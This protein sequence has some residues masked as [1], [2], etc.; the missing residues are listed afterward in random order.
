MTTVTGAPAKSP[1]T[2]SGWNRD[3]TDFLYGL[4]TARAGLLIVSVVLVLIPLGARS[5]ALGLVTVPLA[6]A[7]V[8]LALIWVSGRPANEW[9]GD[10][11]AFTRAKRRQET[12]FRGGAAG[13]RAT[14]DAPGTP[15]MDLPGSLSPIRFLRTETGTGAHMAVVHHPINLTYTAVCRVESRGLALADTGQQTSRVAAWGA[16]LSS[17]C[18]ENNVFVRVQVC[19]RAEPGDDTALRRWHTDHVVAGVPEIAIRNAEVALAESGRASAQHQAY[20]AFTMSAS[21][22]RGDIRV[23]GDGD[24]GAAAVLV[25]RVRAMEDVLRR[26]H[27]PVQEWLDVR[28]LSEVV[29]SGFDPAGGQALAHRRVSARSMVASGANTGL[30]PG[31]PPHLAGPVA[32]SVGWK[33]YRHDSGVSATFGVYEWPRHAVHSTVLIALLG[34]AGGYGARRSFSLHYEPLGPREA[35]RRLQAE[36]TKADAKRSMKAKSGTVIGAS[37]TAERTMIAKQDAET[38]AGHGLVR[39][40]GYVTVTVTD[41]TLLEQ[42]VADLQADASASKIELRRMYGSQDTAFFASTLPL[43]TGLP[44][45]RRG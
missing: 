28:D 8:A 31:V 17:L 18:S 27:L 41:E 19:L 2:Y 23:A 24:V 12:E 40:V 30:E 32:T 26:A 1:A 34:H 15:A 35:S 6:L 38:A 9:I 44:L 13:G 5:L 37:E 4:S 33:Q 7:L 20:V 29:R 42:A 3:K 14:L 22:A 36:A 16:A 45:G 43:G 10:Y 11:M 39:F 25:R 21:K